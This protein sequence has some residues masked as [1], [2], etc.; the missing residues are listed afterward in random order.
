MPNVLNKETMMRRLLIP[1]AAISLLLAGCAGSTNAAAQIAPT[2]GDQNLM[3]NTI[4]VSGTGEVT[5]T[6]DT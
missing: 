2:G 3:S 6:P 4:A 5:G 1:L